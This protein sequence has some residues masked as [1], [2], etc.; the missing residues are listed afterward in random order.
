[1]YKHVL[2]ERG[3]IF[4]EAVA[5][6]RTSPHVCAAGLHVGNRLGML[7][8]TL[9]ARTGVTIAS[10]KTLTVAFLEADGENGAYSGHSSHAVTLAGALHAG[11]G[12]VVARFVLP[13]D[14]KDW[15][16]AKLSCDDEAASGS[17]DVFVEYLAR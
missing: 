10:G 8:C 16:K 9:T 2:K 13:P 5:L 7:A 12:G 6:P 14:A 11:P 15:I 3:Q 4:E 1:M 17:L